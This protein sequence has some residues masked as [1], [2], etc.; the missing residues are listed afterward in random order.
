ML[1]QNIILLLALSLSANASAGIL[2]GFA[3]ATQ[4]TSAEWSKLPPAK[5]P[6]LVLTNDASFDGHSPLHGASSFLMRMPDGEIV[7]GT[8]KHLIKQAGGVDPPVALTDLD[9]VLTGWKVFPRTKEDQAI[10]AKGLVERRNGE[11]THDWLLLHLKD[12][13]SK[14][15]ATPLVPRTDPVKVGEKVFLIGVPY[16]DERS[17][18]NVYEGVVTARPKPNYFTYEFRP[19]VHIPGFSGAPIVDANGLLVGHGVSMSS[20]LKKQNGMEIEFGGEDASLALD[21]WKHRNDAP[22]INPA[23]AVH[24]TLPE[25][26]TPRQSKLPNVL[27][28]GEFRVLTAFAELSAEAKA[29]YSDDTDLMKWAADVKSRTAAGSN[30][31]NRQE[32]ELKAGNIGGHKTAEYEI[33]GDI[34]T[35]KVRYR[36]IMLELN[37]CFCKLMCWTTPNHWDE[38]QGKFEEVVQSVK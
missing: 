18:Q 30:L 14:L 27:Q 16:S 36:I 35:T 34:K 33:S 37:G 5:W 7:V 22:A 38:A 9:H 3:G 11:A 20:E 12:K 8:A 17:A 28:F 29:D 31:S 10:E 26:W 13:T 32:T 21:L 15:P 25:G 23:D 1:K 6:Q 2:G 24:L 4:P 19:P